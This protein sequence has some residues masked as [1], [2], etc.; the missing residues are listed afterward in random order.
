MVWRTLNELSCIEAR[1][2]LKSQRKFVFK[3]RFGI[4][5]SIIL[6]SRL[7]IN[8][9]SCDLPPYWDAGSLFSPEA[10]KDLEFQI[11][12]HDFAKHGLELP[13]ASSSSHLSYGE[14][15]LSPSNVD[16]LELVG[17]N[18]EGNQSE[19]ELL[20]TPSY[21]DL[22]HSEKDDLQH[23]IVNH[24]ENNFLTD[25]TKHPVRQT[26][27]IAHVEPP[28]ALTFSGNPSSSQLSLN[29]KDN[30]E[31]V[32]QTNRGLKETGRPV[33]K[34]KIIAHVEPPLGYQTLFRDRI[35]QPEKIRGPYRKRK[36][37]G[38]T[39]PGPPYSFVDH[40][41]TSDTA[42][43]VVLR[44]I[45]SLRQADRSIIID[46]A[47]LEN[48]HKEILQIRT[49]QIK[50]FLASLRLRDEDGLG[51]M[52]KL[53]MKN[54]EQSRRGTFK[55]RHRLA[56]KNFKQIGPQAR[57]HN[58]YVRHVLPDFEES[59]SE[60]EREITEDHSQRRLK[61]GML[62]LQNMVADIRKGVNIK[63]NKDSVSSSRKRH[64]LLYYRRLERIFNYYLLHVDI[65]NTLIPD[66]DISNQVWRTSQRQLAG[67][68]F[69]QD[70]RQLVHSHGEALDRSLTPEG[71]YQMNRADKKYFESMADHSSVIWKSVT[72]WIKSSRK[73][74]A[75]QITDQKDPNAP[76]RKLFKQ[77]V[78]EIYVSFLEDFTN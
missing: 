14:N 74:L 32:N 13:S 52:D 5:T 46:A 48:R 62:D 61:H 20:N 57:F 77:F 31:L 23:F 11:D 21:S 59:M 27:S 65:I 38:E 68:E 54:S 7:V 34:K 16:E 44:A 63:S 67:Q 10:L 75:T 3:A 40:E 41:P 69:L 64:Q 56:L 60:I 78:N 9:C 25:E 37:A 24:Q 4:I 22:F 53:T 49:N 33:Q 15:H 28:P 47:I 1:P 50:K 70:A 35:V 71:K 51:L 30:M 2:N 6:I 17:K 36:K 66:E 72:K 76:I 55:D 12:L 58:L 29:E 42:Q 73:S 19:W 26:H 18:L 8:F 43:L 45:K 39:D